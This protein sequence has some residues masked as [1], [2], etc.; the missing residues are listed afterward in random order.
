MTRRA[1]ILQR[2]IV[3]SRFIFELEELELRHTRSDGSMGGPIKRLVLNRGDAAAILLHDPHTNLVLLCEQFRAPTLKHGSGWLVELPAGMVDH[4]ETPLGCITRETLE[5]T[6]QVV[7]NPCL[8]S[9]VYASPGGSS[10]RIHIFYDR[11]DL[12]TDL[13]QF[14][15]LE[16]EDEDIR[17][18][19]VDVNEVIEQ[20]QNG[21]ITDAKTFIALQWLNFQLRTA[22]TE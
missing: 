14:G 16:S 10:E 12:R 22:E 19:L 21:E 1:E 13:P 9:T 2:K 17:I 7:L 4:G 20:L 5:E 15:G 3:F 6:G 8:I 18:L 11:V